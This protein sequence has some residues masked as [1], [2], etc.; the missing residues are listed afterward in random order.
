MRVLGIDA[1]W[2]NTGGV[3]IDGTGYTRPVYVAGQCIRTKVDKTSQDRVSVEDARRLS[4]VWAGFE[5][6]YRIAGHLDAVAAEAYSIFA[7]KQGGNAWKTT[8]VWAT[9]HSFAM[10]KGIPF[11]VFLPLDLKR[12]FSLQNKEV[13]KEQVQGALCRRV[14]GLGEFLE[15]YRPRSAHEHLADA[16]G[17]AYL[18]LERLLRP[19]ER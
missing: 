6:L 4:E 11:F 15:D 19:C 18:G 3:V 2:A 7:N 8:Y 17:H 9:A 13:S 14:D 5:A 1:G 12:A 10:A 16:A